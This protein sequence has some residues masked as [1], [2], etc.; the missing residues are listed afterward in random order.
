MQSLEQG[1]LNKYVTQLV[2]PRGTNSSHISANSI[3]AKLKRDDFRYREESHSFTGGKSLLRQ[4]QSLF[5]SE[6]STSCDRST[7]VIRSGRNN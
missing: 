5:Q 2:H 3:T 6:L 7:D 1:S 4:I